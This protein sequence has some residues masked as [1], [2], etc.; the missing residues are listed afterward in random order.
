MGSKYHDRFSDASEELKEH[1]GFVCETCGTKLDAKDEKHAGL[2]KKMTEA[3]TL[4][5]PAPFGP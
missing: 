3:K 2:I 5:E 4:K 1:S